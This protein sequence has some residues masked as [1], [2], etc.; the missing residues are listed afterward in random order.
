LLVNDAG[1]GV[2]AIDE[3]VDL[4]ARVKPGS[5]ERFRTSPDQKSRLEL[6]IKRADAVDE[7]REA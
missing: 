1:C 3:I 4:S 2:A 5:R 7:K 6:N